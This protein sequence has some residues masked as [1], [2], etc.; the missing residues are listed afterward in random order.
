MLLNYFYSEHKYWV[1]SQK[2]MISEHPDAP[3]GMR[4]HRMLRKLPGELSSSGLLLVRGGKLPG[5]TRDGIRLITELGPH[6][7][8]IEMGA[9]DEDGVSGE[10]RGHEDLDR[11]VG[12]G[13]ESV[14]GAAPGVVDAVVVHVP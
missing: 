5:G 6:A 4:G 13:F 2:P 11:V 1:E 7:V 8:D 3:E 14:K 12:A 10:G 9:L